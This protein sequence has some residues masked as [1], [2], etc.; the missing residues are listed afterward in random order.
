MSTMNV[1][2]TSPGRVGCRPSNEKT[3]RKRSSQRTASPSFDWRS[4][5]S[6]TA[7]SRNQ[8]WAVRASEQKDKPPSYQTSASELEALQRLSVVVPDSHLGYF[9]ESPA[10]ASAGSAVLCSLMQG[11]ADLREVEGMVHAA[12]SSGGCTQE[13]GEERFSCFADRAVVNIGASFASRVT[14]K[15]TTEVDPTL[16]TNAEA[17]VQNAH[18]LLDM[19]KECGVDKEKILLKFP[20]TYAG[21]RAV[22]VLEQE[23]TNCLVHLVSSFVQV[24]AAAQAGASVIQIS[25]GRIRDWYRQ[26]PGAI[27]DPNGPREDSGFESEYDP[28][29]ALVKK[30][31]NY[32]RCFHPKTRIMASGIRKKSDALN[33][34]GCDFIVL[35]EKVL[36]E[37]ASSDTASGYN[38]S[39]SITDGSIQFDSVNPSMSVDMASE[40]EFKDWEKQLVD[41]DVFEAKMDEAGQELLVQGIKSLATS[42]ADLVT[43]VKKR[44]P[45]PNM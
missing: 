17:M 40:D 13:D 6:Q 7:S 32:T 42:R 36:K 11:N 45:P 18:R 4:R 3:N 14:G 31:Y 2:V 8:C 12:L 23:G 24:A 9:N 27:R 10:A 19:Y 25:I 34:A 1:V 15:V 20:A 41:K 43:I 21:I 22:R 33:C 16:A 35:G 28:G 37:L 44:W 5:P 39:L 29:L 30:A 38:D 26:H